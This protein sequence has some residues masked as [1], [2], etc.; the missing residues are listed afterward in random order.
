MCEIC[1][2]TFLKLLKISKVHKRKKCARF[3]CLLLLVW[4]T[5]VNF[6]Q[7]NILSLIF[8]TLVSNSSHVAT[9]NNLF[10]PT[11]I[12]FLLIKMIIND[13]W[14][15]Y[16]NFLP[17]PYSSTIR[18]KKIEKR[19]NFPQSIWLFGI[20]EIQIIL[21]MKRNNVRGCEKSFVW[22]YFAYSK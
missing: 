16:W 3:P 18:R 9:S 7:I 10:I 5:Y 17:A 4:C 21:K 6:S 15:T 19:L 22:N 20:F 2:C 11:K 14:K 12:Q 1:V 13:F 8:S